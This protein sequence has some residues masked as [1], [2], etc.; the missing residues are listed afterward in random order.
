MATIE[1]VPESYPEEITGYAEPWIADPGDVIA[2]KV[3][4]PSR[5]M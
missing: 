2:I 5:A 4:P 1:N 3:K